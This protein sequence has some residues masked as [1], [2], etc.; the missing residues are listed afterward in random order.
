MGLFT[1]PRVTHTL[2]H[3]CMLVRPDD[4]KQPPAAAPLLHERWVS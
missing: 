2:L 1:A 3:Q 4:G